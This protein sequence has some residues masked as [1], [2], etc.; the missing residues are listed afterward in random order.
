M[1]GLLRRIRGAI[2]M[3]AA[4][5]VPWAIVSALTGAA[6]VYFLVS[7]P[8]DFPRFSMIV[9]AAISNGISGGIIGFITGTAFSAILSMAERRHTL[10]GLDSRRFTLWGAAAGA[11]SSTLLFTMAATGGGGANVPAAFAF[12]GV[13]TAMGAGCAALT[14]KMA[15]ATS[16]SSHA[17]DSGIRSP[18]AREALPGP[19][20]LSDA[21]WVKGARARDRSR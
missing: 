20:V 19:D 14:L 11:I 21:Q 5:S 1:T 7:L 13:S 15:R 10:A 12:L 8:P 9:Q 18:D 2:G 6:T 4:W 3:G 16:E 17:F